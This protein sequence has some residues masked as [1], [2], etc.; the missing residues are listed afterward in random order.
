MKISP[1]ECREILGRERGY[2]TL[3]NTRGRSDQ[4]MSMACEMAVLGPACE[5]G[6]ANNNREQRLHLPDLETYAYCR[7]STGR[8][9]RMPEANVSSMLSRMGVSGISG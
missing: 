9:A 2:Y 3:N 6:G 1:M 5:R 4:H 7:Y 8:Y